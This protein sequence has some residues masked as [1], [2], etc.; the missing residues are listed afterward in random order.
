VGKRLPSLET[1][2]HDPKTMWQR[3]TV[4]WYGKANAPWRS[5]RPPRCG[6]ALTLILYPSALVLTRD[7]EGKRPPKALFSTDQTQTANAS[8]LIWPPVCRTTP[9]L[10]GLSSLV[11]LFGQALYPDEQL[12]FKQVAKT[13]PNVAACL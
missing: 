1:V 4:D 12:P 3:I 9:L 8:G 5:A 2:L 13:S 11:T 10:F 6:I 7:P